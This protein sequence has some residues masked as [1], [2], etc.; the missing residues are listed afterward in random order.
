M[1]SRG[2]TYDTCLGDRGVKDLLVLGLDIKADIFLIGRYIEVKSSYH[3][4]TLWLLEMTAKPIR[5]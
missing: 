5:P 3:L 2:T 1:F 4:G